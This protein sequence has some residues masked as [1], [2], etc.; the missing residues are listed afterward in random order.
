M[1]F[2]D[3]G[4]LRCRHL[5][6]EVRRLA[7]GDPH[8]RFLSHAPCHGRLIGL[9]ANQHVRTDQQRTTRSQGNTYTH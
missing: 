6:R 5:V 1:R 4:G 9:D 3:H 2:A 8:Y 7:L